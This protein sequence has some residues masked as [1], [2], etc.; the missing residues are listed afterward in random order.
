MFG[1]QMPPRRRACCCWES[2]IGTVRVYVLRYMEVI[3]RLSSKLPSIDPDHKGQQAFFL[4]LARLQ[5]S[6]MCC[7]VLCAVQ[8]PAPH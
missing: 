6:W 4:G 5:V 1:H 8:V 2:T 7:V 3:C